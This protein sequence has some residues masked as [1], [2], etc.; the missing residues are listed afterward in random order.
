MP[1]HV[2]LLRA[3]NVAG[4]LLPMAEL[5][6]ICEGLGFSDVTTYIA[7]GNVLFLSDLSETV[8]AQRLDDALGARFGKNPGVMVRSASELRAVA[9]AAPFAHAAPNSLLVHFFNDAPPA[10]ALAAMV[11]P[12]GEEARLGTREIYVHYPG[13]SGR[14]KLKLPALKSGTS[15]NLNTVRKLADMAE[16]MEP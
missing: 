9:D 14:S 10:D 15:R 8:A 2:A 4:T 1:V 7:S 6:A 5:K 3:V 13:G 11:A 12:G 16:A